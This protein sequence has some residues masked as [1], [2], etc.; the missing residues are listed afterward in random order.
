MNVD[1]KRVKVCGITNENDAHLAVR[2]GAWALGFIFY[3]KSPRYI[4]PSKAARIIWKLPPFVT[5]VGVFVN[6][7]ASVVRKISE[8]C[9]IKT[10]QFHGEET[11]SYCRRFRG[12]SLIKAFRLHPAFPFAQ[13]KA[14]DVTAFLFDTY[15]PNIYGG[16]GKTFS[17]ALLRKKRIPKPVI[18]SGGLTPDNIQRAFRVLRPYAVDVCSG[19]EVSPGKKSKARLKKFFRNIAE[20]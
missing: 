3:K 18:L 14:Y 6:E 11:P 1:A 7:E 12:Y 9:G 19:V 20:V 2:C 4:S 17:W 5:P 16:T 13:L 8:Q 15:A 10:V